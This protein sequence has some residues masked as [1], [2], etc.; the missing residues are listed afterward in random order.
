[1]NMVNLFLDVSTNAPTFESN[2]LSNGSSE[3][4]M[5]QCNS[6][7]PGQYTIMGSEQTFPNA[8]AF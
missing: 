2:G 3:I 4:N 7:H 6:R 5:I 1:M 8:S